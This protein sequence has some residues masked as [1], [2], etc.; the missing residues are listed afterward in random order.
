MNKTALRLIIGA[1]LFFP[2]LGWSEETFLLKARHILCDKEQDIADLVDIADEAQRREKY[3][4]DLSQGKCTAP[5][6]AMTQ[7]VNLKK[8][9]TAKGNVYYC[10]NLYSLSVVFP[11][12]ECAPPDFVT[13]LDAEVRSR[14]GDY[15]L[16]RDT[17][18][19]K[20]ARCAEAGSVY[21]V[22]RQD[23]WVR[24]AR[25]FPVQMQRETRID[26]NDFPRAIRDGCKGVDY[27]SQPAGK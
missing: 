22:K 2:A 21:L 4:L 25:I 1:F 24:K 13:T 20:G 23:G 8:K 12:I 6:P 3:L 7:V 27:L 11:N 5:M 10:F 9:R 18:A 26:A 19:E 14:T 16:L 17:D 15:R